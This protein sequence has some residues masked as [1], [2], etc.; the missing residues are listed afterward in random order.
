[1]FFGFFFIFTLHTHAYT[2]TLCPSELRSTN[3]LS[4]SFA[5]RAL[6]ANSNITCLTFL[7]CKTLLQ[8]SLFSTGGKILHLLNLVNILLVSIIGLSSL[9]EAVLF[10]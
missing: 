6:F 4:H 9:K 3:R 2:H 8:I 10:S 5:S 7:Q 1:M